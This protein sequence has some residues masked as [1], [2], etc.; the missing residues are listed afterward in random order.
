MHDKNPIAFYSRNVSAVQ[1][2]RKTLRVTE[3]YSK[4][5]KLTRLQVIQE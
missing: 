4:L 3:R 2:W 5:L 1:K